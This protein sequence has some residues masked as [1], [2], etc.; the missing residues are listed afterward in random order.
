MQVWNGRT[1]YLLFY[2]EDFVEWTRHTA[3]LLRK[4]CFEQA[5]I[6]H[7][8]EE[9]E[10]MGKR[11]QRETAS[12]VTI[13]LMHLLK[14]QHQPQRRYTESGISSWLSTIVE[15]RQQLHPT[16]PAISKPA[17]IWTANSG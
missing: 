8:A 13:L 9:I 12:L 6:E 5:D 10:D 3:E 2:D 15:Q 7:I 17:S 4:H 14:W 16:I 11:D 1:N